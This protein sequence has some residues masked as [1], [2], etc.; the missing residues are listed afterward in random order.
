MSL[1]CYHHRMPRLIPSLLL[2][3]VTLLPSPLAGQGWPQWGG[4]AAHRNASTANGQPLGSILTE[5]VLDPFADQQIQTLGVLLVHYPAPILDG[6]DVFVAFRTGEFTTR[7]LWE[8]QIWNVAR[9]RWRLGRLEPQWDVWTDWKPVPF[10]SPSWEPVF[11]PAID[12]GFLYMPGAGGSVLVVNRESGTLVRRINPFGVTIDPSIFVTGPLTIDSNGS[13][14]YNAIRLDPEAPWSSD[15]LGAWLVRIA[16]DGTSET[17]SYAGLVPNAPAATDLCMTT[18][19]TGD[20][21]WPPSPDA[22]PGSASCGS[23]RP[24]INVAPAV[25]P[26]GTIYTVSRAHF[27]DR[28]GYLV[29]VDSD[30]TP[31]WSASLRDRFHDGCGVLLPP[32]GM[33]GGCRE[34]AQLGVDPA[35][36]TPGA[37]IVSDSSSSSPTIAP[38]GTILY[39]AFSRYNHAAGHLMRFDADGTYL[40]AYRY[41]WDLTPTIWEHDGTYSIILKENRYGVGSYCGNATHCPSN[42]TEVTPDD[43]EQYL[44]TQLDPDLNVEWTFRNTNTMSCTRDPDGTVDCV[45]DHPHGFEWCVNAGVV[46]SRGVFYANGE[47]GVLYAIAQG[48][49]LFDST[50]LQLALGAAYTPVAIGADGLI[51][52]QNAGRLLVVGERRPLERR[53]SVRRP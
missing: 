5:L 36:N 18:F 16:P 6:P 23:Q 20:L 37:G 17:L 4:D 9:L 35:D 30:F 31:K 14:I 19:L 26:D 24:G 12:A 22:V 27:R 42:R 8:T 46:D 53:R 34:G 38:D 48:G 11:H 43:P 49:E 28:W 13:I 10:G 15:A 25:A 33:P 41:G 40:G 29:A 7:T 45:S 47:D 50:F 21:P 1:R 2:L 44:I 52:A 32:N 3:L 51:Y 39:G